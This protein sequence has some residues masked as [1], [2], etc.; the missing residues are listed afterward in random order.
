MGAE[1]ERGGGGPNVSLTDFLE[2][3]EGRGPCV[4]TVLLKWKALKQEIQQLVDR[5]TKEAK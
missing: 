4:G 1:T 3:T 5:A 2:G